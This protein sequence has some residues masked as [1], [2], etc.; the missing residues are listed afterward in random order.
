[1]EVKVERKR[2]CVSI[3]VATKKGTWR[4]HE[5][6][7]YGLEK[8]ARVDHSVNSGHLEK[9]F[10][11]VVKPGELTCAPADDEVWRSGVVERSARKDRQ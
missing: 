7:C 1:M 2:Y 10:P 6:L 11:G 3:K 9:L 4:L 8:I 5:L